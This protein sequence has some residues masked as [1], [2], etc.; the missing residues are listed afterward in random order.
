MDEHE[1]MFQTITS[2]LLGQKLEGYKDYE[3]WGLRSVAK[4]DKVKSNISDK[5]VYLPPFDFYQDIKSRV[6]EINEAYE[7]V[8]KRKLSENDLESLSLGNAAK[9]LKEIS[10]T[11]PDTIFG[12]NTNI[13]ECSIYYDAHTCFKT[14]GM[15]QT[16]GAFYSFWP[17]KSEYTIGCYYVFSSQ[18]CIKCYNSESLTRCF[19][20]SDSNNC[21]DLFFSHNCENVRD[22][23]FCFNAKNLKNAIGN[24]QLPLAK[25][26]E[27]K[28]MLLKE[29]HERLKKDK[30]LDFDIFN[31]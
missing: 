30:T 14:C 4:M 9:K 10:I 20:V 15:N 17:R 19:E 16:K 6:V 18:F 11:T 21:S 26:K 31:F 5:I 13:S 3:N 12:V 23:M 8:G 29:I 7:S 24:V 27:I 28:A 25:Y 2:V 1:K 22:S